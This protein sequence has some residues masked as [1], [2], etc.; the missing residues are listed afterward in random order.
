[1]ITNSHNNKLHLSSFSL[2]LLAMILMLLDHLGKTILLKYQFLTYI[3][4]LSFPIF[5]F[6]IT[7]GLLHTKNLKKYIFRLLIFA[8]LSEIPFN[9]LVN[10]TLLYPQHQNILWTFLLSILCITILN[11]TKNLTLD[12]KITFYPFI[13]ISFFL[14]GMLLLT[15]YYGY[16][17]L[18]VLLFYFT[19]T[20]DNISNKKQ[21][22]IYLIQLLCLYLISLLIGGQLIFSSN[23][24]GLKIN[25]YKQSLFILSL[26][27]IWLYNKK[28]GLYNNYIKYLYYSFYPL[29]MLMLWLLNLLF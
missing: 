19:K 18:T 6:L 14:L 26:P 11:K 23:L 27:L 15:D 7:E 3:G 5:A 24:F 20:K 13:I 29:H 2:H 10:N 4:R 8:L 16:G 12:F 28:Q 9:L 1:M 17:I 25:F 21:L 22:F